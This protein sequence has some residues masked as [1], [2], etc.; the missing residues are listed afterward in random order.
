MSN[1][2]YIILYVL[3]DEWNFRDCNTIDVAIENFEYLVKERK[4]P[5][6]LLFK[7]EEMMRYEVKR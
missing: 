5:F 2:K 3:E 6:V 4:S 7:S 1:T